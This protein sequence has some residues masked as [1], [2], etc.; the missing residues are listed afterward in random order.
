MANCNGICRLCDRLIIST[1]VTVVGTGLVVNIPAGTYQ[2]GCKYCIVIAQAIPDAATV[3]MPV[4]ISIGGVTTTLYPLVDRCGVQ[5]TASEIR[6][7]TKY[8]AVVVTNATGGVFRICGKICNRSG[9]T[10][11][12]LMTAAEEGGAA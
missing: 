9:S 2:N 11:D 3:N 6:T 12:A 5:L 1:S 4:S 8:A 7:R 10:L